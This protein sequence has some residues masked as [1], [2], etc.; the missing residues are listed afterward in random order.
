MRNFVLGIVAGLALAVI[1]AFVLGVDVLKYVE[2]GHV[3]P[4]ADVPLTAF[5]KK[6]AMAALDAALDRY[7]P[8]LE[9]PIQ[10]TASALSE[11]AKLY[12]TYCSRCHGAMDNSETAWRVHLYPPA[13]QFP[14][15]PTDMEEFANFYV[16]KHGV[17]WTGMPAWSAE[18]SD[19]EIWTLVAYLNHMKEPGAPMPEMEHGAH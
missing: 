15:E 4:R 7:A 12:G 5:E 14:K 13:P 17:R 3:D 6:H 18:L 1:A 10:P 11:G 8:K 2:Q 9:N 19:K 16:I